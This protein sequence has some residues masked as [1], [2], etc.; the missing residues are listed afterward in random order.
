MGFM[1]QRSDIESIIS[2]TPGAIERVLYMVYTKLLKLQQN[3]NQTQ[4]IS[5]ANKLSDMSLSMSKT[6]TQFSPLK[7]MPSI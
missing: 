7:N 6:N 4:S 1:I 2:N 3:A 5:L